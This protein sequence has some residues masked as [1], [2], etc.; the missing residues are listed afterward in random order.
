M[1]VE[2]LLYEKLVGIFTEMLSG[3]GCAV[4]G[5][6]LDFDEL[7]DDDGSPIADRHLEVNV[8]NRAYDGYTAAKMT[9]AVSLDARIR[10]EG[11]AGNEDIAIHDLITAK[12][13]EYQK[14]LAAVQRDFMLDLTP[15]T[16]TSTSTLYFIP[17]GFKLDGGQ[18]TK[19]TGSKTRV[20]NFS[21]TLKATLNQR[22]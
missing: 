3:I 1:N 8:G 14:S 4:S 17:R 18:L 9:I 12:L 20:F 11:Y 6:R 22:N 2:K 16:S 15:S 13:E 19:E 7:F 21:F 5:N 10:P